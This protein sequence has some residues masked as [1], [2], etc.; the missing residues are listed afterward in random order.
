M[1]HPEILYEDRHILVCVKPAGVLAE[2]DG[3]GGGLPGLFRDYLAEKGEDPTLHTVHRLDRP[4][5]GVTILAKSSKAAGKLSAQIAERSVT[6]EYLAVI[7]GKT[8]EKEGQ[9]RDLLFRDAAKGK[10]YVVDRMRR[11]VR[12]AL[13]D[14]SMLS[15]VAVEDKMI[16]LMRIRLH[17]GRTHQIRVQFASRKLPLFGDGRYGSGDGGEFPALWAWH[18]VFTHPITGKPLSLFAMPSAKM[19]F[20]LF[21][22]EIASLGGEL[23]C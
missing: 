16:S 17:T 15:S 11:G 18:V 5:G 4:V 3:K 22:V 9:F 19:P 6:K 8:A 10:T 20:S 14:Y 23:G 21:T 13:L 1:Q 2:D 7:Y 12:E